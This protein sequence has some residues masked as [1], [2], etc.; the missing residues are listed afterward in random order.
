M[1][2][3]AS[4][5][6]I[7]AI[8][9][10]RRPMRNSMTR[11]FWITL[12]SVVLRETRDAVPNSSISTAEKPWTLAKSSLRR[13]AENLVASLAARFV[14]S[15]LAAHAISESVA[16]AM[17]KQMMVVWLLSLTPSII[18]LTNIGATI[19]ATEEMITNATI[20]I[21]CRLF[22][23]TLESIADTAA[24]S[25]PSVSQNKLLPD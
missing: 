24:F 7:A 4:T 16:I 25:F 8:I 6:P 14:A 23:L 1:V 13:S 12:T 11:K 19:W 10:V 5:S 3:T 17:A 20:A 21:T 22:S 15:T 18:L 9:G 2:A